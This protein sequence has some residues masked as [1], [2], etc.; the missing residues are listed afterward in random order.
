MG[1]AKPTTWILA[2]GAVVLG[3]SLVL[4]QDWPQ[5]RG[6]NR[7]GKVTGFTAPETWPEQFTER[8]KVSVGAADATPALVGDR[9]YVFTRQGADEVILCLNAD[10]GDKIW[11]DKYA[12]PAVTGAAAGHPGPRSSPVVADGKVCTLGV[13]GIVSCLDATSGKLIWRKDDSG[14][15]WPRFFTSYSPIIVDGTCIAH[16]GGSSDGP[17]IAYDLA[18]GDAKWKWTGDGPSYASPVLMTVGGTKLLASM[19][20]A[21][22]VA[23]DVADGKTAW[24]TP[25]AVRGRGYN[26]ATPIVDG[27]TLIY[28]GSGRGTKAVQL[29]KQGD[30]FVAK[31]LW[32]NPLGVQFSTPVLKDGMLYGISERGNIFCINAKTGETAWTDSVNRGQYGGI[33]DAGSVLMALPTKGDLVVFRPD[34]KAYAQVADIKVANTETYAYPVVA[35]KRVFIKDQDNLILW[36][37]D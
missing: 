1:I 17:M 11:D 32:S 18:T 24:E 29:E 25:F 6:V 26:A 5:W 33:V 34:D 23:I 3:T 36:T 20:N 27:Q 9:L 14:G 4:A 22:V 13:S 15:Q 37:I 31:D 12:A 7:D 8:W 19:T 35:G 10:T 16:V 21:K 28:T 30:A 2:V